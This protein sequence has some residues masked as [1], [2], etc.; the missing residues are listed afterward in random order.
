MYN[1]CMGGVDL[2]DQRIAAY[3]FNCRFSIKFCLRIASAKT[4]GKTK[5]VNFIFNRT[6]FLKHNG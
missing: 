5:Q 1:Q 6:V 2:V 4:F 3:H